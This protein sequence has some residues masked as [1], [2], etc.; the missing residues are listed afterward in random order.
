MAES[1]GEVT[2][3]VG[4]IHGTSGMDESDVRSFTGSMGVASLRRNG[5]DAPEPRSMSERLMMDE[6]LELEREKSGR[7]KL[8]RGGVKAGVEPAGTPRR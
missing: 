2:S 7:E 4:S 3:F 8:G 1:L 5:A 6:F